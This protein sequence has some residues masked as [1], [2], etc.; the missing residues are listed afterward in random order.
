MMGQY[1]HFARHAPEKIEYAIKRY[2][3]ESSR[4]LSVL[5]SRLEGREWLVGNSMTVA[6]LC[7]F[8][9]YVQY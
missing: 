7:N 6:D 4:L 3:D 5:D 1:Y 9:W 8:C 2:R